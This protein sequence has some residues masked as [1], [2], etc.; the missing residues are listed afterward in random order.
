MKRIW[1]LLIFCCLMSTSFVMG[2]DIVIN[3]C[4]TKKEIELSGD[5]PSNNDRRS[6]KKPI[7]YGVKLGG[8]VSYFSGTKVVGDDRKPSGPSSLTCGVHAGGFLNYSFSD[9]FGVQIEALYSMQGGRYKYTKI[10]D[11]EYKGTLRS[12][13]INLPLLL[14]VKPFKFP[15]SFLAG[16]QVGYCVNR[17]FYGYGIYFDKERYKNFDFAVAWGLQYA[18]TKNLTI[19]FRHN[20]GLTPS[21]DF[22]FTDT[23]EGKSYTVH[24]KGE[25]NKVLHLSLGWVF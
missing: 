5:F 16:P 1:F 15:L 21:C 10:V 18:L 24:Y 2:E 14:E 22:N 12:H 11:L 6:L 8:N 23:F 3:G 7:K 9:L 13:Y 25:H 17:S 20:I 19:G 4:D